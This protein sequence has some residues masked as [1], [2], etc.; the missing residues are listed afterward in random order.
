MIMSLGGISL[1]ENFPVYGRSFEYIRP[2]P[3]GPSF[4]KV[5]ISLSGFLQA[6]NSEELFMLYESLK[7]LVGVNDT[8]FTYIDDTV[9]ASGVT[10]H[11]E[12]PVYVESYNEPQDNEYAKSCIGDYSIEL[13]YFKPNEDN[14]GL[15]VSYNGYEFDPIPTWSRDAEINRD[16]RN[17]TYQSTTLRIVLNGFIFRDTHSELKEEVDLLEQAFKGDGTLVY[18]DFSNSV[19]I[20]R[21]SIQPCVP[22]NFIYYSAEFF[23]DIFVENGGILEIEKR[24]S[25][26]RINRQPVITEEP[27]CDRR[28]I[29]LMNESGQ[30]INYRVKVKSSSLAVARNMVSAELQS[31]FILGGIEMPGGSESWDY[32][33]PS[34]EVNVVQ[35]HDIPVL[36]NM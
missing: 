31:I 23:Y 20:G 6:E 5:N 22:K 33:E 11:D 32:I 1:G 26:S 15:T 16:G 12:Q 25:F 18:G 29:E 4:K 28:L 2:D 17:G 3:Q 24:F 34:V 13:Y 9:T 35:F 21:Y 14:L 10:I 7:D 27:F 30:T 19:K 8:T 36:G